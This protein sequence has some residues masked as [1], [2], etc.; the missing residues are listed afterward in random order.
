MASLKLRVSG[1]T[2]G[3]CQATVEKALKAVD[4]TFGAAVFLDEG[5]AE[6]DYDSGKANAE[7]YLSAVAAA[8]YQ[9][10]VAD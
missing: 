9:A 7:Q 5:E 8:G 2:C 6:V 4:G 3:H 1:M 10:T